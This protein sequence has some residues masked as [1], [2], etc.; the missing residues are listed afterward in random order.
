MVGRSVGRSIGQSVGRSVGRSVGGSVGRSVGRTVGR[1]VGP[2]VRRLVGRSV[3]RSVCVDLLEK[4]V[5]CSRRGARA[6]WLPVPRRFDARGNERQQPVRAFPLGSP[7]LAQSP[8]FRLLPGAELPLWRDQP[9]IGQSR[10]GHQPGKTRGSKKSKTSLARGRYFGTRAAR[11][12]ARESRRLGCRPQI[13]SNNSPPSG[14][15]R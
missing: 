8:S 3:G 11:K 13:L 2:S 4:L 5:H 7:R 6:C 1:V 9:E 12:R 10:R 14:S 15:D